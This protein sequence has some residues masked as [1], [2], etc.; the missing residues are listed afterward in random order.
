MSKTLQER[1]RARLDR[2]TAQRL[3]SIIEVKPRP[4]VGYWQAY[5]ATNYNGQHRILTESGEILG[6]PITNGNYGVGSK[7]AIQWQEDGTAL[8]WAMPR[9]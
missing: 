7:V 3:Q 9:G 4:E 2:S 1:A 8:F 5:D 6:T